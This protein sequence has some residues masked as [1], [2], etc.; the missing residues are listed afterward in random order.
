MLFA[1]ISSRVAILA[2][3]PTVE[4]VEEIAEAMVEQGL[5]KSHQSLTTVVRIPLYLSIY[6]WA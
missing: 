3:E 4:L 6:S 5:P 1:A 2:E